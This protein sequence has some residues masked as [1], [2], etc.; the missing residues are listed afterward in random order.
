MAM[1]AK[2]A[3]AIAAKTEQASGVKLNLKP[4]GQNSGE[5]SGAQHSFAKLSQMLK[6]STPAPAKR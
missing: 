2:K 3:A 6:Y 1:T 5:G 4:N